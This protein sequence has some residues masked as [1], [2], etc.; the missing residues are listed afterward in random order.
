MNIMQSQ[1]MSEGFTLPSEV[2]KR[3]GGLTSIQKQDLYNHQS[4]D[5][6]W[7][8]EYLKAQVTGVDSLEKYGICKSPNSSNLPKPYFVCPDVQSSSTGLL[9][10]ER[11]CCGPPSHQTCCRLSTFSS[12]LALSPSIIIGLGLTFLLLSILITIVAYARIARALRKESSAIKLSF[13]RSSSQVPPRKHLLSSSDTYS[14]VK[15]NSHDELIGYSGLSKYQ[16]G[17]VDQSGQFTAAAEKP[18]AL[19]ALGINYG[20]DPPASN[21]SVQAARKMDHKRASKGPHLL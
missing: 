13:R 19:R 2:L 15:S 21:H 20:P 10:V 7:I 11:F 17:S 6:V 14:Y 12:T 4:L 3:F 5:F 8:P 9:D 16:Q 18:L 1:R